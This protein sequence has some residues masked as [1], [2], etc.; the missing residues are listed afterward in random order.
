MRPP[1]LV[2]SSPSFLPSIMLTKQRDK[3]FL[4]KTKANTAQLETEPKAKEKEGG[5]IITWPPGRVTILPRLS[6]RAP[7]L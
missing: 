6:C 2:I 7:K 3:M 5:R 1:G 4:N